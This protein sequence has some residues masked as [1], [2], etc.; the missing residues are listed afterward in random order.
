MTTS[1]KKKLQCLKPHNQLLNLNEYM[2]FFNFTFIQKWL[3][4]CLTCED[5]RKICK[6]SNSSIISEE[7]DIHL[8]QRTSRPTYQYSMNISTLNAAVIDLQFKP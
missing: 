1:K 3:E 8:L 5:T 4:G 2:I 7:R 6:K